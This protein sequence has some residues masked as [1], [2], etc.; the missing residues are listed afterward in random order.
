MRITPWKKYQYI[1]IGGSIITLLIFLILIYFCNCIFSLITYALCI[2]IKI[3]WEGK[4][5]CPKCQ[6]P[7]NVSIKPNSKY[8]HGVD[9]FVPEKC[10]VCGTELNK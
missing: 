3:I 2:I 8:F 6:T 4:I 5:V 10:V 9:V 1:S 7:L